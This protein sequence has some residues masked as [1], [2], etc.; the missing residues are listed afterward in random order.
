[1]GGSTWIITEPD[2]ENVDMEAFTGVLQQFTLIE[3]LSM[4]DPF[5]PLDQIGMVVPAYTITV[6]DQDGKDTV[7][8]VGAQT[9]TQSGYYVRVEGKLYVV[10]LGAIDAFLDMLTNPPVPPKT[11]TPTDISPSGTL[12]TTLTTPSLETATATP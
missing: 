2:R 5:P 6:T 8:D 3:P 12:T 4:V 1:L 7:I 11:S 10:G 9:P